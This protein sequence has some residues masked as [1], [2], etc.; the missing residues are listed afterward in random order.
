LTA[1]TQLNFSG[2]GH[3]QSTFTISSAGSGTVPEP[4]SLSLLGLGSR[5]FF[6]KLRR[7]RA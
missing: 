6:L 3:I 4:G 2:V 7:K 1:I 5:V